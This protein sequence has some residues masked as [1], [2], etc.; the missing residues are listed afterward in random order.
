MAIDVT[1]GLDDELGLVWATQPENPEQRESVN[2]WIWADDLAIALPRT[3]V[4]AV[5]DQWDTHDIQLNIAFPDGRVYNLLGPGAVHD[6]VAVRV[7]ALAQRG[8]RTA[9][10]ADVEHGV[11]ALDRVEHAG[12][13]DDQ[14][15]LGPAR[16]DQHHAT[17]WISAT[18][19]P[20]GPC[21]S[22]S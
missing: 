11:D 14:V 20:T 6:P 19:T 22:R 13:A 18:L 1:G 21:V 8:D 10:H 2:A 9:V 17:S 16:G 4:E 3:G 15:V 7:E 12:A 5:A